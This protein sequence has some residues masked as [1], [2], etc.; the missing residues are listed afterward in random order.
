MKTKLIILCLFFI[1]LTQVKA[2]V[3]ASDPGDAVYNVY[4]NVNAAFRNLNVSV[5]NYT[6]TTIR[7]NGTISAWT[8]NGLMKTYFYDQ[9]IR[10]R[11]NDYSIF[12][13]YDNSD[14]FRP[15]PNHF[16]RCREY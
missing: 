15:S 13:L 7:C 1:T 11:G 6:D 3:K 14:E 16:I 8:R 9:V 10:A 12:Y 4:I 5:S 2:E